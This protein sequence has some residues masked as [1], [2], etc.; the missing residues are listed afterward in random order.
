MQ[1]GGIKADP[2]IHDPDAVRSKQAH[3]AVFQF[4]GNFLFQRLSLR[5]ALAKSRRDDDRGLY[6]CSYAFPDNPRNRDRRGHYNRQINR[7][8]DFT[9]GRKCS[10]AK[11]FSLL[12]V[13][14]INLA[15]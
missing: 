5:A 10:E 7:L 6:A 1:E 13:D 11:N 15:L 9:D 2:R 8:G 3:V 4:L 14:R 12:W